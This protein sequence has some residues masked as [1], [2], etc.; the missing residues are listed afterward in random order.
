MYILIITIFN[1]I[2]CIGGVYYFT[3]NKH[4]AEKG[5]CAKKRI[6][7]FEPV[8]H[9]AIFE[10]EQGFVKEVQQKVLCECTIYN[11]QGNK[12]L[13]RSQ[14]EEILHQ[15]YDLIFTIGALCTQ[16]IHELC[17]KKQNTTP[18]VFSS[19]DDPVTMGIAKSL[20]NSGNNF[21]GVIESSHYEKQ[22]ESLIELKPTTKQVLLVYDPTHGTG[23]LEKD[24]NYIQEL[25]KQHNIALQ[26]VEIFHANELQQKVT[27]FLSA[28]DTI[29]VLKDN[30]VVA[31]IDV[32]VKLCN[33]RGITLYASD[34][35][36]GTKGAA[37]AYGIKEED[38]GIQAAQKALLIVH[39]HKNPTDIPITSVIG[40]RLMINSSTSAQ[41]GIKIDQEKLFIELPKGD[42]TMSESEKEMILFLQKYIRINTMHPH[43][44]YKEV[45][46][47]FKQQAHNDGFAYQEVVLPSGNPVLIISYQGTNPELPSLAL[48]H[49][50]DIVPAPNIQEWKTPPLAG[51]IREGSVV[52]RGTQ[53]MKGIGV[54]HYFALK[55]IKERGIRL[56]RTVHIFIVPDEERGG[57]KGTQEFI[58]TD[59]FKALHVGFVV[60]EGRAS[61][62]KDM[63]FLKIDERKPLQLLITSKGELAHGSKL[64]SFNAIHELVKFLYKIVLIQ[65]TNREKL[66]STEAGLL[67]S[68]NITSLGSGITHENETALNV[69]PG[70]AQA[71]IDIRVPPTMKIEQAQKLIEQEL[72]CFPTIHYTI[73]ATV[74][75]REV[76]DCAKTILYQAFEK[77]IK[78]NGMDVQPQISEGT[79]D[80][81]YYYALGI[82]GIGFTPF[83]GID[84]IH[85][86]NESVTLGDLIQGKNI[87]FDFLNYFCNPRGMDHD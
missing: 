3:L 36:S 79:S 60:D 56:E 87:F 33:Q 12:T 68:M 13:L 26:S 53:D 34:L 44:D 15:N 64:D 50:M 75:D 42:L 24:K 73:E 71:T 54:V 83:T 7:I 18:V 47:L 58:K 37:L 74:P 62:K 81:R 9:P 22:I 57:F 20:K 86:T 78:E 19:I 43:P 29:L 55:E 51:E 40:D 67:L 39:E 10:I 30:T 46:S 65:Q 69:I 66:A 31:G 28:V 52:G 63:L 5:T 61:G 16:T 45:I 41:Q 32:L 1:L 76:R 38:S 8:A 70:S 35:N 85:G 14:A 4:S 77:I 72:S 80:L 82:C 59:A 2:L 11:A 17:S 27:G 49:H 25:L 21:T 84:N 6:A 48:N 23:R